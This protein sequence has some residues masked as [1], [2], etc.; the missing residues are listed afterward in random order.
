MSSDQLRS[1]DFHLLYEL[2]V[3]IDAVYRERFSVK[4]GKKIKSF[5]AKEV[6]I[7][8]TNRYKLDISPRKDDDAMVSIDKVTLFKKWFE[9][10]E[11]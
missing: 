11:A 2:I 5:T 3:K 9:G 4:V 6:H 1:N 8:S 7:L 10:L